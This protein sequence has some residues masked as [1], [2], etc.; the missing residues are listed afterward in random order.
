MTVLAVVCGTELKRENNRNWNHKKG[1]SVLQVKDS[2]EFLGVLLPG[3]KCKPR[4]FGASQ[5]DVSRELD[6]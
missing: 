6:T 5:N 3:M 4:S 1:I 2:S